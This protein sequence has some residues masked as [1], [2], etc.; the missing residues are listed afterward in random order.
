MSELSNAYREQVRDL[1]RRRIR[2]ARERLLDE[3]KGKVEAARKKAEAQPAIVSLKKLKTR[4]DEVKAQITVLEK[5]R[6]AVARKFREAMGNKEPHYSYRNPDDDDIQGM[7]DKALAALLSSDPEI[8]PKLKQLENLDRQIGDLLVLA[9]TTT[10]LRAVVSL[11]NERLGA[12]ITDVEREIL[13]IE[14]DD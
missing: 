14:K 6:D 11:F 8:G 3:K 4:F 13:G 5:E 7:T 10:K 2:E 12:S 1:L 9:L